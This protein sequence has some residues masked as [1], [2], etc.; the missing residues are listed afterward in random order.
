MNSKALQIILVT[1]MLMA[2][3][4]NPASASAE[5]EGEN[6]SSIQSLFMA[7]PMA[8]ILSFVVS[9]IMH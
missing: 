9:K 7:A 1:V 8:V 3:M 4:I 5:P 6:G 2:L